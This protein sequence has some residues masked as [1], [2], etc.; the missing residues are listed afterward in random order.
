MCM[1]VLMGWRLQGNGTR[2]LGSVGW[3][4][5]SVKLVALS[6]GNLESGAM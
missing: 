4:R 5:E 2:G 1:W 6:N 3:R